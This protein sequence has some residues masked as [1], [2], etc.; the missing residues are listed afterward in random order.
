MTLSFL[1]GRAREWVDWKR[2]HRAPAPHKEAAELLCRG[3]LATIDRMK[4][5][6]LK[7]PAAHEQGNDEKESCH[8]GHMSFIMRWTYGRCGILYGRSNLSTFFSLGLGVL[9]A[10]QKGLRKEGRV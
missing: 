8:H 4:R 1:R 3:R 7:D 9:H 6:L 10:N 5:I 2:R